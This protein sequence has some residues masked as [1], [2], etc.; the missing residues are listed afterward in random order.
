M[1]AQHKHKAQLAAAVE[2]SLHREHAVPYGRES[3][4]APRSDGGGCDAAA[5]RTRPQDLARAWRL[6]ECGGGAVAVHE[7]PSAG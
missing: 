7:R 1:H 2:G 5:Q 6:A 4:A 3:A